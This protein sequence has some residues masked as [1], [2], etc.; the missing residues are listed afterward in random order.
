[1]QLGHIADIRTSSEALGSRASHVSPHPLPP[2][3]GHKDM[4]LHPVIIKNKLSIGSN[5]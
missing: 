2:Y 4:I 3:H 5:K 1:M